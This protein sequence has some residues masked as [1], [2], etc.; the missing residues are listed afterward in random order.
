MRD[1]HLRMG[2]L[3]YEL[4]GEKRR[5]RISVP[6]DRLVAEVEAPSAKT[7]KAHLLS[8]LGTDAEIAAIEAAIAKNSNFLVE[9][10]GLDSLSISLEGRAVCYRGSL[11][12]PGR[13]R[14]L[15]HL[16]A[17]S[18]TWLI[19]ALSSNPEYVFVLDSSPEFVWTN[20]SYIYGL[21]GLPEWAE[22]FH[23]QLSS[24]RSIVPLVGIGCEPAL[25]RGSQEQFLSWLGNGVRA[26]A[27]TFAASNGPIV[28]PKLALENFLR[29]EP[30][31]IR[32]A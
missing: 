26:G 18:E 23:L 13:N 19:S 30:T 29:P 12:V 6:V 27:L 16:I 3:F 31:P 22:W 24:Q 20:V 14:P 1:A 7:G 15:R 32:S 2:R 21:P 8:V 17:F 10:P 25:I 4:T 5:T 9:A 28:W 11:T